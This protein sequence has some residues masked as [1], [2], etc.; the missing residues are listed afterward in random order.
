VLDPDA[1]NHWHQDY[2][3]NGPMDHY[4]NPETPGAFRRLPLD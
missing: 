4:D 1:L 3:Q 2:R